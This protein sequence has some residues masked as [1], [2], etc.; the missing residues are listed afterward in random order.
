MFGNGQT[1]KVKNIYYFSNNTDSY[2]IAIGELET[3]MTDVTIP[4]VWW[5]MPQD[6]KQYEVQITGWSYL[7]GWFTG[8]QGFIYFN[9]SIEKCKALAYYQPLVQGG[10]S[11]APIL[12]QGKILGINFGA[13]PETQPY[14]GGWASLLFLVFQDYRSSFPSLLLTPAPTKTDLVISKSGSCMELILKSAPGSRNQVTVSDDL[15]QWIPVHEKSGFIESVP[16]S[17]WE[18]KVRWNTV[19]APRAF[20]RAERQ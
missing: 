7:N 4:E 9:S 5:Q 18:T 6:L 14:Q 1:R 20:F 19:G 16:V 10:Y 17:Q 15:S 2:D 12:Y 8:S 11:G 3:P 13:Y